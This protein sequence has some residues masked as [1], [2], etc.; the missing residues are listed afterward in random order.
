M[1]DTRRYRRF[2]VDFKDIHGRILFSNNIKILNISVGGVAFSIDRKLDIGKIY[3]LRLEAR[4]RRLNIQGTIV[5][6]KSDNVFRDKETGLAYI[7]GMK[8]LNLSSEKVREIE[9]FIHENFLK[10]QKVEP[11]DSLSELRIHVRFH[12]HNPERA[13]VSYIEEYKVI[14]ISQRGMLIESDYVLQHQDIIPMEMTI[15]DTQSIALWGKIVMCKT[16]ND[17]D[18]LRY[19]VGIEFID[20]SETDR[21]TLKQF[22]ALMEEEKQLV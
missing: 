22:I 21:A 9:I 20:M 18:Y 12:I 17:A 2:A 14:K 11:F 1:K 10:Y 13:T 8:F 6:I 4:S 7:A 16:M 3:A 15:S 5:W 19:E